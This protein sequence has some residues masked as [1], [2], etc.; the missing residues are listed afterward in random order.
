MRY[1]LGRG[2]KMLA[3]TAIKIRHLAVGK[4]KRLSRF[5]PGMPP[6]LK[7]LDRQALTLYFFSDFLDVKGMD[8]MLRFGNGRFFYF[9]CFFSKGLPGAR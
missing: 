4:T 8:A 6:L 2:D 1:I 5:G 7:K 9:Y 3:K